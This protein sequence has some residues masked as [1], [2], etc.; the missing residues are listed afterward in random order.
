MS[1]HGAIQVL[2]VSELNGALER[3]LVSLNVATRTATAQSS[4][5]L[6][7]GIK[8]KLATSSHPA[9]TPTPSA[10]GDPPSL[11]S[12]TLRRSTTVK[13]PVPLGMGR[14]EAQIGPTAVYGRIQELGGST[15]RGGATELPPRPFVRPVYETL[16]ASGA[17]T[18]LYHSAW[19]AALARH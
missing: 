3:L 2:G 13:G 15:G 18:N 14:W 17:L 8:Q 5:L 1:G 12:G 9:G 4:H 16:A 7:R 19:R 11:V 10:P 6:E